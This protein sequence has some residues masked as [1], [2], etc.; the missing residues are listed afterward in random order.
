MAIEQ[1]R[2]GPLDETEVLSQA[3]EFLKFLQNPDRVLDQINYKSDEA[4]AESFKIE[5]ACEPRIERLK[6]MTAVWKTLAERTKTRLIVFS[7]E[8]K[9]K[10]IKKGKI[11]LPFTGLPINV[12]SRL[13]VPVLYDGFYNRAADKTRISME[14]N[15]PR[16]VAV[17][18]FDFF[19]PLSGSKTFFE[20]EEV[21]EEVETSLGAKDK[22]RCFRGSIRDLFELGIIAAI[23]GLTGFEGGGDARS[24]TFVD[25]S[26]KYTEYCQHAT[27]RIDSGFLKI[28]LRSNSDKHPMVKSAFLIEPREAFIEQTIRNP[29]PLIPV[30]LKIID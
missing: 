28:G 29:A 21:I 23:E 9:E 6:I 13:G 3:V 25:K 17:S 14:W 20:Q 15:V 27:L 26:N 16:E 2:Q 7:D 30:D 24:S 8:Q 22:F 4:E 5:K 11:I 18:E 12:F 19:L 10:L 1:S